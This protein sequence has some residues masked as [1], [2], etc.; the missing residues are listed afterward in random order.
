MEAD[1][2]LWI[3]GQATPVLDAAFRF[4]WLLG[5]WRLCAPLVLAAVAWHLGRRERREALAWLALGLAVAVV[6]ELLKAAV[7]RPRPALWPWLLP[8]SGYAFPSGHATAG[9]AFYPLLGWLALRSRGWAWGGWALG[10]GVG[11]FVGVG[12]LYA[13]VHWPSD[14]VAGWALGAALGLGAI[15]WLGAPEEPRGPEDRTSP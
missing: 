9:A 12:R 11:V 10:L 5:A 6:P 1:I 13:G 4:S 15:L 8:T 14:V 7:A 3:H 2:L